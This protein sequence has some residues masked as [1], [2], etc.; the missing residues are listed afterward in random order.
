VD[1]HAT[2]PVMFEALPRCDRKCFDPLSV[3]RASRDM[4]LGGADRRRHAPMDVAFEV[5]HG[6]LA[7][8]VV[9]ERDVDVGVDQTGNYGCS[10]GVDDNVASLNIPGRRRAD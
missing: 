6:L 2:G 4:H 10:I 3:P 7:R 1:S 5:S 9:A 8:C